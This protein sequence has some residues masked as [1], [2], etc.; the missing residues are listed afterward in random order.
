LCQYFLINHP[1][2]IEEDQMNSNQCIIAIPQ[3]APKNSILRTETEIDLLERVKK[4]NLE[5]V[6]KGHRSGDNTNNVSAT[7]SIKPDNW[8]IVGEW[9]WEN[10][11]IY[12]GLSVLPYDSGSYIQAPFEDIT[13]EKYEN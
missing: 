12:N 8:E 6:K 9:M 11:K 3:S 13:K 2:L 1:E 7:I 4:F 10:R 5:W